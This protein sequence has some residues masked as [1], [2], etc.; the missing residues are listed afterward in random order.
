M[1]RLFNNHLI[2][3]A[4]GITLIASGLAQAAPGEVLILGSTVTG[5][6][7]SREAL[8][9]TA[10]GRTP[11]VVSDA[12]WSALTTAEFADYDAIVIGDPTCTTSQNAT[13][14]ASATTWGPAIDGNVIIIGSDPVYHAGSRPGAQTL[15]EQGM[16]FAVDEA[17]ATGG[18]LDLSCH[19]HFQASGTPV[20]MLDGINGGGFTVIG[21]SFLPGLNNVH[22]VATHPALAG[23]TDA[24]LSNWGNSVHE[25]FVDWPFQFESLAVALDG[26]GSYVAPD[27]SVGYPYILA[28]GVTVIS[29][30]ALGPETAINPIGTSHTV[31]ATVTTSDPDPDTPV[32]GTSVNFTII[33]GPHVGVSG[34]AVTD[35]AG[36]A[37]FSYT[38][39]AVGIDTIE[40]TFIDSSEITQR[41][42]RV[43]KEWVDSSTCVDLDGDGYG[44]PGDPTCPGGG[45]EDCDDDNP[46]VHPGVQEGP[47]EGPTCENQLDD[48]CDGLIDL[49]DVEDCEPLYVELASFTA[50][51]T[52]DGV[53]VRWTTLVEIDNVG[54]RVL[55][56]TDG[57]TNV[58]ALN[59]QFIAA[60]GTELSGASYQFMD[61]G[62]NRASGYAW[63]YLEDIDTSGRVTR[64]GPVMVKKQRPLTPR[65]KR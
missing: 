7:G 29:D 32:V 53:M 15:I 65:T 22:I 56:S 16:A 26:S 62:H 45:E 1:Q 6:A 11:V 21:A 40:A 31:T 55:R 46:A 18:Y 59:K 12:V 41:S 25:G 28:R 58:E 10:L 13:A 30:I 19:F 44:A 35:A 43:T 17:G 54:F 49:D 57:G 50:E 42:N 3:V 51:A 63:Y 64:H 47:P 4:I 20:P 8:A 37:S 38:G 5:G 61:R 60:R 52:P 33:D 14:N 27:G 36:Q 48:D 23:L 39:S 24:D 34:T 9:A 2:A